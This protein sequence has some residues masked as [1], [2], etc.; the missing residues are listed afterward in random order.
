MKTMS[1]RLL[2]AGAITLV[3][4]TQS[5]AQDPLTNTWLTTYSG[6]YARIYT[7]KE[8]A[9]AGTAVST[10]TGQTLPA[11]SDIQRVESSADWLYV[12]TT[13][14]SSHLMGPWYLDAAKTRI[15]DNL[16]R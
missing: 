11:Y 10:W 5:S 6:K 9:L 15:F 14:L 7:S 1:I 3:A 16:P 12:T 8:A 4:A 13:G 2:L